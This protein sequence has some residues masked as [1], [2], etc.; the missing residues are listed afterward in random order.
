MAHK[1]YFLDLSLIRAEIDQ[2]HWNQKQLAGEA[3]VALRSVTSLFKG[4]AVTYAVAGNLARALNLSVFALTEKHLHVGAG[5]LD[6]PD[7]GVTHERLLIE[8]LQKDMRG[9]HA[10]AARLCRRI[11]RELPDLDDERRT[12]VR[13]KLATI[14]DNGGRHAEALALLETILNDA[15]L[16][17][18][19]PARVLFWAGYHRALSL[20]RLRRLDEAKKAFQTLLAKDNQHA[21]ASINHQLGV[22]YLELAKQGKSTLDEALSCL[23]KS[24]EIWQRVGNHREGFSLR[25]LAEASA[26]HGKLAKAVELYANAIAVFAFHQCARYVEQSVEELLQLA[27]RSFK[28]ASAHSSSG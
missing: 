1:K 24:R 20:R 7:L 23:Q 28:T 16:A 11:L 12:F 22:V 5:W 17:S 21:V 26:L 27:R 8:A 18:R 19:V 13:V 3:R 25:R 9:L 15:S 14:I 2:R 6:V 4:N 10:E